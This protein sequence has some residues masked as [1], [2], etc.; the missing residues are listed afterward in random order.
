MLIDILSKALYRVLQSRIHRLFHFR[1][2][3]HGWT[4]YSGKGL[5][6]LCGLLEEVHGGLEVILGALM[7]WIA[8][9]IEHLEKHIVFFCHIIRTSA[10][11]LHSGGEADVGRRL[12]EDGRI[13]LVI[14]KVTEDGFGRGNM[15]IIDFALGSRIDGDLQVEFLRAREL[16][17]S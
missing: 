11:V 14:A 2:R 12:R 15:R 16:L 1:V 4:I 7:R 6:D 5:L 17:A 10:A 9:L 8:L 3:E 13:Q